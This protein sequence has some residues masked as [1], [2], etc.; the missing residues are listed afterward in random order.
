M[1]HIHLLHTTKSANSTLT[2]AEEES[3]LGEI[4][5]NFQELSV[6]GRARWGLGTRD[7]AG[8]G[9]GAGSMGDGNAE[10]LPCH[11]GALEVMDVALSGGLDVTGAGSSGQGS[12]V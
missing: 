1:L 12:R 7:T 8:T 2:A 9:G 3:T 4:V 5:A 11:L 6:L 10:V